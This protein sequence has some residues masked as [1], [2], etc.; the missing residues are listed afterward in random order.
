[1]TATNK[2]SE[3]EENPMP[4]KGY[5]CRDLVNKSDGWQGQDTGARHKV[6]NSLQTYAT[7]NDNTEKP[8][9]EMRR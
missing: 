5:R 7:R 3:F 1:M 8:G 9:D 4:S 2:K 6:L